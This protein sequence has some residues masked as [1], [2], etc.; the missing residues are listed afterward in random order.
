MGI[1][2]SVDHD[3]RRRKLMWYRVCTLLLGGFLHF[4]HTFRGTAGRLDET[5][6]YVDGLTQGTVQWSTCS[7]TSQTVLR[8]QCKGEII[9]GGLAPSQGS[10]IRSVAYVIPPPWFAT[11]RFGSQCLFFSFFFFGKFFSENEDVRVR[12]SSSSFSLR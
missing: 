5:R 11:A 10:A 1:I 7:A 8:C 4:Y 9:S 12:S 6:R 2:C 3:H